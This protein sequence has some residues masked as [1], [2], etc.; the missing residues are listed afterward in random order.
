[1]KEHL[2]KAKRAKLKLI[3]HE[4]K[5]GELRSGGKNGPVVTDPKQAVAIG[6]SYFKRHNEKKERD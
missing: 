6:Y 3:M 2:D 5:E 4:F 1:M